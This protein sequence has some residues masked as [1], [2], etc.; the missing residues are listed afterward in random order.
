LSECKIYLALVAQDKSCTPEKRRATRVGETF[1]ALTILSY[2]PLVGGAGGTRTRDN[3]RSR[4]VVP[5][6]F[7]QNSR[8][9][10]PAWECLLRR[11]SA[12]LPTAGAV[13]TGSHAGAWEPEKLSFPRSAWECR[14][15]RSAARI[16]CYAT[17]SVAK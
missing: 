15:D 3:R 12:A 1:G 6:A 11:S 9:H 5:P 17:Q 13:K 8:S 4:H 7:A 2:S 10:A 16:A 14:L